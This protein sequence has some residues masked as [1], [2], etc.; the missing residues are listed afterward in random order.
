MKEYLTARSPLNTTEKR[1]MFRIRTKMV[2]LP[3]YFPGKFGQRTCRYGCEENED[4]YHIIQCENDSE[5]ENI[6]KIELE[7]ILSVTNVINKETIQKIIHI[8]EVRNLKL[9][10]KI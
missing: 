10:E 8:I 2:N 7:N 5:K 6:G 1:N 3:A 4:L 9:E